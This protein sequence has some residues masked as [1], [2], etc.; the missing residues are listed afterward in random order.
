MVRTE[1]C[2]DRIVPLYEEA[3]TRAQR[4]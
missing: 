3:Y 4:A 1:Y 2:V